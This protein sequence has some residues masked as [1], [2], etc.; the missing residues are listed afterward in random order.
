[1][2]TM[3]RILFAAA[4]FFIAQAA[5]ADPRSAP[6]DASGRAERV[7][8]K[9]AAHRQVLNPAL[10]P[11]AGNAV[12]V[13]TPGL[14]RANAVRAYPPSCLADPLPDQTLGP[15]Y[16]KSVN[17]AIPASSFRKASPSPSGAWPAAVPPSSPRP[18]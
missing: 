3:T 15:T 7:G 18:P 11:K 9:Q 13:S 5:I 4:C 6:V 16:S 10:V 2:F 14:P 12:N 1:M 8:A 17:L